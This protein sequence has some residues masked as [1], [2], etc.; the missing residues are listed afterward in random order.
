MASESRVS[1]SSGRPAIDV[2]QGHAVEKLHGDERSAIVL[3]D[4][5][6][7]ADVRMVQGGGGARFARKR[8][9]AWASCATLSGQKFQG[10]ETAESVSS[11]L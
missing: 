11:A 4:F 6:D 7:G 3:A 10:D 8:S 1:I 5:V 9:S 2:L